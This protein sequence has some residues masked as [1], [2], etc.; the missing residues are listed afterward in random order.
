M[1]RHGLRAAALLA[2]VVLSLALAGCGAS[3]AS[4]SPVATDHVDLPRSY[5]FAPA[6]ITVPAG[7]TVTWTNDDNFTHSVE[8]D[9][10]ASPGQVL[11]PGESVT[12]SFDA[13]GSFHY[14]CAF[15][16]QDMEGTVIVTSP[17][18]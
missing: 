17:T 3:G 16:A 10:E 1:L 2:A 4:A 14:I 5:K 13:A 11:K 9:G 12:K 18:G 15:H 7:T 6:V 8:F